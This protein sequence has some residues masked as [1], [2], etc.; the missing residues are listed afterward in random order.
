MKQHKNVLCRLFISE[1]VVVIFD[2]RVP[3][4]L[5]KPSLVETQKVQNA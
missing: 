5:I 3:F 4:K 2:F 1:Q